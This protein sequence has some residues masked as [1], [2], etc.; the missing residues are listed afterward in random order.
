MG[1]A[2]QSRGLLGVGEAGEQPTQTTP[3][4]GNTLVHMDGYFC[5]G[6]KLCILA[7]SCHRGA[8]VV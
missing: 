1:A 5:S 6:G 2:S 3:I 7:R 4:L 8:G